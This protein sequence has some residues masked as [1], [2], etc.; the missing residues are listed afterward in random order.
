MTLQTSNTA[1]AE[2][3]T[4]PRVIGPRDGKAVDLRSLGVRFIAWT[5]ETGGNFSVVEHPIPPRTLVAPR[6]RHE[7][8]DEYSFV[9]EG[10]MGAELGGTVVEAGPGDFVFKPR[11]QWH[12]FWNAGDDPCRVLEII[13]PGGF[14][15]F[16][17]ELAELMAATGAPNPGVA[18]AG[19]DLP[20]RFGIAFQPESIEELCARHGL[21]YPSSAPRPTSGP[22]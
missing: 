7:R 18:L 10:R 4:A 9:F 15:R 16:F 3:P 13:S 14:E 8:E 6:H 22:D 21:I 5:G 12:T 19:S 20:E 17:A 2:S 11:R 1:L